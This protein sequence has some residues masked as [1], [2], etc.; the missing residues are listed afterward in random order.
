VIRR[1]F[2][3]PFARHKHRARPAALAKPLRGR[4]AKFAS[5][6][7]GFCRA[8][9]PEVLVSCVKHGFSELRSAGLV[10]TARV[11]GYTC[12]AGARQA[13]R[14]AKR[15]KPLSTALR[16]SDSLRGA[17]LAALCQRDFRDWCAVTVAVGN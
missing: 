10:V 12:A 15:P 2:L 4:L 6:A 17:A 13:G 9:K 7:H 1:R 5:E 16:A 8:R 11:S 14:R 3:N